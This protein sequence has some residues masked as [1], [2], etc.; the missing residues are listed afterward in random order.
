MYIN[1]IRFHLGRS[2]V[3]NESPYRHWIWKIGSYA[4]ESNH[5]LH[6]SNCFTRIFNIHVSADNERLCTTTAMM[7]MMIII[8]NVHVYRVCKK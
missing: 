6:A 5:F 1:R 2:I 3:A 7:M 8:T 4:I